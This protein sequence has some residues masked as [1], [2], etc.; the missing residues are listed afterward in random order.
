M[1]WL[2]RMN[3]AMDY[4]EANLADEI[5]YDRLAQLACC[6]T[7]HLQRMFPFLMGV[8][9]SEY[10]R[11]RRLTLAAFELQTTDT[12]V[13]DVAIKYGY[14]SPEAFSRAFKQQHGIIPVS[15]RNHGNTLKAYPRLSFQIS[16]KGDEGM[17][18]RIVQ[19]DAFEMFGVYGVIN[20]DQNTAFVEVPQFRQQC[21]DD[22][23]VDEINA[24]LGRYPDSMLHAA[25]YD[26]TVDTFKYMICYHQPQGLSIPSKFTT[27]S[28]PPL[29]WVIFPEPQCDNLQKLWVRIYAE[30]FPTSEYEQAEGPTFEM[31]YGMAANAISEIWI[32]VRQKESNSAK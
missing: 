22:F 4:I 13:I 28:V 10:I 23:S 24:L 11:R 26:H 8:S 21:D 31:Y 14:D 27:L 7:Y 1:D 2:K 25:L 9:I 19:K 3:E 15:A 30:W 12:K 5:S 29:R 16:I 32:P 6:S 18:Y 17:N 20:A